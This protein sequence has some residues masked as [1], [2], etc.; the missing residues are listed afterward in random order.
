MMP[1][2]NI[3]YSPSHK[4]K[5]KR[6]TPRCASISEQ[7]LSSCPCFARSSRPLPYECALCL[8]HT[9]ILSYHTRNFK[10]SLSIFLIFPIG[11]YA[12]FTMSCKELTYGV[13][14][15]SVFL[16]ISLTSITFALS[17]FVATNRYLL[18]EMVQ[19]FSFLTISIIS[20]RWKL[21]K[22]LAS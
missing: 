1:F 5:Q 4:L 8:R 2:I 6:S 13:S 15:F 21:Y 14:R 19:S 18:R 3:H 22:N 20:L 11:L 9:H 7:G 10:T 16:D 17:S 12:Y